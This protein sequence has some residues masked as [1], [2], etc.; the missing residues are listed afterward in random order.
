MIN[1]ESPI[2]LFLQQRQMAGMTTLRNGKEETPR[3]FGIASISASP[4]PWN[5]LLDRQFLRPH[6]LYM[7]CVVLQ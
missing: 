5:N 2:H 3:I 1:H 6:Y 7:G 4:A